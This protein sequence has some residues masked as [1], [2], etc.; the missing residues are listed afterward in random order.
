MEL[1][2][3]LTKKRIEDMAR[4]FVNEPDSFDLESLSS[5]TPDVFLSY[6]HSDLSFVK[7][8]VTFLFY[9]KGGIRG[10]ADRLDVSMNHEPDIDTAVSI[11]NKISNANKVIYIASY[12]SL[13]SPWCNWEIGLSDGIKGADKVAILSAKA[14]N[15]RWHRNEY[16]Q[17]YPLI[18]YDL[19]KHTF[20]VIYPNGKAKSLYDWIKDN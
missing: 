14:N 7:T 12:Q 9:A 18:S 20:I 6:S 17:Q 15:G 8:V 5:K 10:Y 2:N 1:A 19:Q 3:L 16:L 4:Q 13:K 11:K